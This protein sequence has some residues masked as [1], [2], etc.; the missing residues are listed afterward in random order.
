MGH[1]ALKKERL[2]KVIVSYSLSEGRLLIKG[3]ARMGKTT[4]ALAR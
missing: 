3:M 2:I 1:V 4:L